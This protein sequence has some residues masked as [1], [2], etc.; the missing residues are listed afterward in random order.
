MAL[1]AGLMMV[2]LVAGDASASSPSTPVP[3]DEAK[4][5]STPDAT[6]LPEPT[7]EATPE[8]TPEPTPEAT[9]EP[10]PEATPEPTPEA[11]PEPTPE[12]TPEPTPEAT[13]EPTPEATPEPTPEATPE[14]TPEPTPEPTATPESGSDPESPAYFPTA[15]SQYI[16]NQDE[17]VG[18][19]TLPEAAGGAGGFTYSLTPSLPEGLSFDAT[20]RALTGTPAAAGESTMTYTATDTDGGEAS[21]EFSIRVQAAPQTALAA[22]KP[23]AP[24]L[25]RTEFSEESDPALDVTWTAPAD[26]GSPITAYRITYRKQ[27][28]TEWTWSHISDPDDR[29]FRITSTTVGGETVAVAAGATYEA[30]V[31]A[32]SGNED[33]DWSDT[34]TGTANRPPTASSVSFLGGTLGVGG[35]FAWHEAQPQGSGAFFSDA[36]SDTLTYSASAQH[37]ALLGVSL[38]GNAGAAVLTANLL[39]QGASNVTYTASDAY[40]GSVTRTATITIT[41][42]TAR[43]IAENSAAGTAVG[44]PVTG[45]PYNDVALS[46]TLKGKAKDSGKFVIDSSSGQISVAQGATLDYETDDSNRETET[47]NGQVIAKFYRGEVHYT[48]DGH[49]AVINV[50]IRVTDMAPGKP[51]TPSVARTAFAEESNPA[52]DVTWTA[53]S[54]GGGTITGYQAQYR[55]Q[56]EANWTY[57]TGELGATATSLNLP[58]LDAG[59]TYEARVRAVASED[60]DITLSVNPKSVAEYDPDSRGVNITVTATREGTAGAVTVRPSLSGGT[61]ILGTDYTHQF[62]LRDMT[63]PD[64]QTSASITTTMS[65]VDDQRAEGSESIVVS[66][67]VIDP[68]S[69]TGLT[70]SDAVFTIMDNEQA[71][72]VFAYGEVGDWSDAGSGTANRPPTTTSASFTGGTFP[73]G[74]IADYKESGQG[75]LGVMFA[76]ADGDTLTYTAASQHPA[77][78]GVSLSGDPGEAQL[79]ATLLNQGSSELTYTATDAYGGSVTRSATIGISAKTSRSIAEYSAGGTALGDP[80]TGTPYNG[81][82][83]SYTLKGKAADSGLFVIDAASG[84]ISVAQGAALDYAIDDEYREIEYWQGKVFNKFYRGEVHYTVDGHAAVINVLLLVTEVAPG[85]PGTP[86]LARTTSSEPM[87]PALDG[88]WT[89]ADGNGLTI[90][91]YQVRYRT[92]GT[93]NW[94]R[95][96]GAVASTAVTLPDLSAGATYEAQVRTVA[97]KDRDITLSVSPGS[98]GENDNAATRTVT[99]TRSGTSGA[100]TVDLALSGTATAGTDY[101]VWTL[102]D[103]TI[104][105]GHTSGS[106]E[107]TFTGVNDTE[108][109]GSESIIVSGTAAGLTVASTAITIIDEEQPGPL[110]ADPSQRF[111]SWSNTGTGTANRPP[112]TT[113]ASFTGGTFPV[114]TIADYKESGQGALGVMFAD[115]DGD[116]LTYTAAS[117]HPALLGVSLS[118]DPGEAQLRATLLNQGSSEL[119][120]TATDAYGGSVTRSATIGITAKTSRSI[121]EY[122]AGGT[123]VGDPVTGT[124]YNNVALSYTLKGKAADSGLF[125]IDAATGQISV[126]PGAAL[127]YA[128]DDEYREIEYWQGKVFNK[129]YRGEVHYTVDGHAAVINVL[130]VVTEVAPGAPGTPTLARTTSSEP[131]DPAL[132]GA[133]TAGAANGLTISGYQVR[134][135]VKAAAGQDP[136]AWT[137]YTGAVSSTAVTLPNLTAGATYEAQVRTV[138]RKDRDITLSVSPASFGENSQSAGITVTA[139]RSGT[140]G[141]V[142]VDLAFAGTATDGTDYTAWTL[143]DVTIADGATSGSVS[144]TFTGWDDQLTEGSE[145]IIV[146]G[147]ATGLTVASTAI[148][149]ID[150]EQPGPLVA[151]PSQR[152]SPWSGTGEGTANTPPSASS[153]FFGGGTL[154]MGGS[155]AWHETAPLGSGAFFTDADSDTLT[156]AAA[157]E[158][159]ALLGVSLTGSAG[160]AVLTANLLNQG[161]S[162]VNYTASDAYG[163]TVTRSATIT[164]TAKTSR[165]IAENSAAGTA[166][167]APVTGT[168]YNNVALSYTLKGKAKDSGKFVI[169]AATGQISLAQGATLDYETDDSHRETETYNGQVIAKFYR[170]EVHYTVN[171]HDAMINV[172]IKVTDVEAGQ[173]N[174]P[175]VT[176][177]TFSEPTNPALDVSWTAPAAN[178]LTITGYEAQYR[179]KAAD[180]EEANAWTAYTYTDDQDNV[181]GTLPATTT[182]LNLPNVDAGATYEVQVRAVTS[183]EGEGPWSDTGSARANRPPTTTS[184]SFLGGT[185]PVGTVANYN[186]T[187]SG[188]VGVLFADADGDSLTYAAAAQHPAL[189]GVSLTGAAAEAKLQVTL[190]NQGS[191]KVTYTATDAYG[192]S[193]TRSATIGITAKTSRSIAE[194]S[195]A[196]TAV[197]APVT[198][199]PY[200]DGDDQTNDALTYTL[201]GKAKDSGKFVIDSATGQISLAQGA[202]LDYETDDSH[203]ETET[204]NG[205]VIAKFYRGEV[206]YTVNSHDAVINVLIKVTDVEAGKPDA[207]TLTRTEFSEPTNPALDVTWTAPD[208][209]GATITGYEVQYRKKAADGEDPAAWTAYTYTDAEDNETSTLPA[210][211]TSLNLPDLDAGATYEAQVR[212]VTSLEG[213]GPWSDSGEK[214]ANTPP[215][216]TTKAIADFSLQWYKFGNGLSSTDLSNGFFQDADGD[217]ISFSSSSEYQGIVKA[218]LDS[219]ALKVRTLNP[220]GAATTVTYGAHDAYGGYVSRTVDVTGTIGTVQASII[221]NA[222]CGRFV[223][224][225]TGVPYNGAALTYTLTGDA[226]VSGPFAHDASSGWISLG[227][228]KSLDYETKSSYTATLSWVVQQQTASVTVNI[229]VRDVEAGKPAKPTLAR[230]EYS[231]PT[232]PGLD[233]TWT[234]PALT[235]EIINRLQI[236]G[237]EVQYRKKAAQGADPAAWTLYKYE[238]PNNA[239][240]QISE[241]PATPTSL[242]LPG[243]EA[244]ATYE[245][246]VRAIGGVEGPGPWSDSGEKQANTPPNVTTKAIADFSLQWYK[247]GNGLSSTD[248]SNGFF[249]DA[250]GDTISFSSSSEY[251]GVVKAWLDS[252]A[253]K[254][255]TLN[256][257]GAAT[258]VTYGAHD[259]YGGYVSR[260][261]DVTGTIGTVQ[262][263]I[264]ENACCGRFVRNITGVPYNGAALTY[265]LTGDAFVSGPFAHDASSGWI[266]LGSGKSLDYETKSSYTATLSWVVQQQTASVTVNIGVRD[267][268]AGKPAKPTLARTEYS[269]PTD[270]G[271]D[272][273]WT[274]PALTGEIINRLQIT[275]YEVQYRKKAAQGADPAAWTLYKY[276]DPNNAGTQISE[277]PATP[278][279]LTLP[280]LEAGATYEVQVRAIGGVE[281]PGPW[282]DSGEGT[283]NRPPTA[284]SA[285]FTGGSFPVGSTADYNET[286]QGALG[287]LF[288]D[289]D[290]DALTYAAA[291]Q[292][293]ALLGVSLSGAA[294]EA[295]LQATLLNQGSSKLTYTASDAYGGAVTRTATIG[296]TATATRSV[297]ESAA[298]GTNVGAPVTGTPYNGVAL[299]YTL[300]GEADTSGN[301]EI[302]SATGQISVKQGAS[303]DYETKDSYSGQVEYT[304]D[305]N[306]SAI[307]LTINLTD[308][309]AP[310]QPAAPTV[311]RTTFSKPTNPALDVTWSAP[312]DNGVTITG[313]KAQYRKKA[314]DGETPAA[315]TSFTGTVDVTNRTLTLPDLDAGATYEVQVRASGADDDGPWSATGEGRANRPPT[316]TSVSM[317]GGTFPVGSTADYNET[318]AGALGV[319]FTDADS[320]TLTYAAAA[321]Q[322]ALLGVSLSGAAES[323][324]LKVTLINPGTSKFTYTASDAYGGSVTRTVTLTGTASASRSVAENAAAGTAVGAAVT[325]T[326]YNNVALTYTLTGEAATSGAFAIDAATGQI[327]VKQGASL[328]YET[329]SSYSGQVGYTVNGYA[330]AITLTISLTDLEAGQ[331]DAPTLVRTEFSEPSDPALDVTWTAPDA[332]GTSISGYEVQYRKKAADG[333]TPAAWTAY[334]YTDDED[335]VTSEL[336]ATTTSLT[337]PDLDAGATYEVQVRARTSL[338]GEGPW[339]TTGEGTA[340]RPPTATSAAFTGGTYAVGTAV[341]YNETG[342]GALGVLFADADGDALTYAAAAQHPALLG[343]SLTGAAGVAKLQATL[344]NQGTS[345]LTYTARDVY[346]GSVTRTVTLIGTATA[347]RSVAENAAAGTKV[348]APVTGTPYNGVALSY[349]LTGEAATSGAFEIDSATGQISVKQGATLDYETKNSYA[350]QVGYTVDGN[351]SAI[352]LTISLTDLEAGQP[353]AP[354]VTRTEYSEP[355]DPALDV[356]WTA[357]TAVAGITISGYEVQYRKKAAEGEDPAAWTT[358]TYTDDEDNVTSELPATTT[359]LTLPGLDAGATYEVQVRA[360]SNEGTGSWSDT[361][362]GTANRPPTATSAAFTGGTYAVGTAVDYN[363][364][365]QGALGVLFADADGD[366]LTY[367]AAAQHPA[368]LGVSLTGAAGEAKLQATLR[369]QGT[370]QLTYTARDAYGGSV[371]RTVTLIGTATASRSVAENAA[372][373]TKVGAPVTGTPYNGVALSYALTGE[374]STSGAFEI[375]SATGQISVKQGATLD[376]ETKNSYAGQVG[377]TVDGNASAI[378]LTISLTDLEAGQPDAPTVTRT[379]YSEPSD[380]A[381]DVTWTAPTAVAGITISGYEAQ[382]RKKAAE[383][384]DPAAWT[385]YTYT[386]DEDNVTSELPATTT[387]LTLPGLDAGATYEVQVRALSNEGTG[388]WSDTGEGTANR[389]PTATSAAFTGGTYAVGTAVDYNET[390]QGALGVLFADADGDTLTYAAAAQHPALLGVSLT[391]AAGEAKLQA[392]LRNQGTSQ[393]TYT[394]RDAYGGSVTRTVTLIGTASAT[395]SVAENAAAGTKVGAPVTGTP[396][397]N[398]AL[399]YT[400]TGEAATSGAFVI[401]SATGQISVKQGAGLDYETKSSYSGQVEY[402]VDGN[403]AAITLT[404]NLTDADAPG[405][406]AAPTVTRTEFS[407][408]SNPALDVTWTAPTDNGVAITGYK[409]QYRKKAADGEIPAAWTS[410]TG[411]VDV[412]NRTLTLPDLTAGA[413]YEVQVRAS[414]ADDDGPWS[415]TGEGT[416]NTPPTATSV[417]LTGGTHAVGTE[418]DYNETGAGAVG[419]LFADADNDTLTYAASAQQPALLGV[420]LSGAA[421]SAKLRVTVINPGTSAVSYVASDG[422]GGAVT[423]T[424]S[425]TGTATASRSVAENATAGTKV[426]A[427][428]TGTPYNNVALTYT[429][430]GEAATSGAFAIDAATGQISV[431]QGAS[432]DYETKSSYSGQV[433]YTVNGYASAITL[434]ISLTDLEAGQPDAPTLV[435]TEFSEPSDPAL[436]VTWTAPDANGTSISG[437]EVQYRKKAADGD[438]PAAW[439]AYTYTDDEDNVTSELPATTTSLTLPDLDAGATYE[440]QVRARTSLEGEGPWSTTGQGTAN[441]PPTATSAAFTGGTYAVGTAVDYNE[442]GQGALGVLFADADGDALTYAA[443]AQHPALLGVSLT[444]AAGVAKLQ[445]TLR[446]QGTSQLTYT[447]RDVYGGS[448]TRTVTL[449]GTAT[450]SRSVAENAAAGTKVGAPVTGTPYN[451]VALSYSLT[452]EAATSGAFEIDSATGQI[453]VKQGAT[454]DYETKNSYTGQVGYTVDG[455][456]SAITVTINVTDLTT[457]QAD[458]PTLARTEFSEPSDP[459]LDVTWTAPTA[460]AGITIS[461][462]E[463]QYRKKA[464]EGEQANA[465]TAYTYTDDEDNVTSELPATTTS[466]TLPGLDAGATYE[467]QVRALSNEGTGSWSD[468]GEGTANRPP[469]ATSAAFT[470]GTYAVGTAVDFNETG[471]GALG[472]LFADAD[473]DALTYA[474]AAQH[475]ALLGV[476]LTGAAGEA[477]LQATLRNQGTS[478]LT[479]TARDAYGGSVTRTVTLIGTATASRSVAENAAAGTKV[480][481]PVTGTPYNGVA[482]SYALT[483]EASTSG[484]FE[485]DSATGQISVKQGATLDYETKNS[486]AG[487]VGYTVDGNASA[488]TLTISLTDLE[489]GQPDAPTVTRTEYSEPSDP[490]LDVTWTAPTAVAGITISGYEVQYRKKAAEGEDPAAWTTYTYTDDEDNVTSELPAT[491][492]S[493]TLPGLDAGATYEVQVRALSNEGTGSW[494]D[495]GEGTANRP[496]TTTAL[497]LQD[498]EID[499]TDIFSESLETHYFQDPDNDALS[500]WASAEY[501]GILKAEMTGILET[502]LTAEGINP[503]SSTVTYGAHDGYGGF[504]SR[505]FAVTVTESVTR[506]VREDVSDGTAVGDPVTG[507]PYQGETLTYTLTGDAADSGDFTIDADSGQISVAEGASLDFAAKSSYSGNV[508]YTVQGQPATIALTINVTSKPAATPDPPDRDP[509]LPP[510]APD[511]PAVTQSSSAPTTSLE[512]DWSA[513]D[514]RGGPAITDYDVEY[515]K[516]ASGTWTNHNF[517]GTATETTLTGLTPGTTYEVQ[518]R[519]RNAHGRSDWSSPGQGTTAQPNLPPQFSSLTTQRS[520]PENSPAGTLV[521]SPVTATDGEGDPLTYT[522]REASSQFNLNSATGQ[523]SVAEGA[524]LDH[525]AQAS[526]TV[527]IQASD[528][529]NDADVTVTITVTDVAEP[530]DQPDA[531][532]VAP[533]DSEE[534]ELDVSWTAPSNDGRPAITDYDLRYRPDGDSEWIAHAV[535]GVAT[536]TTL[537][538][539]EPGTTYEVQVA[540]S[541]DEGTSP[542]SD[543]GTGRTEESVALSLIIFPEDEGDT[544]TRSIAENS[545]AGTPVGAPVTAT[546]TGGDALTYALSGASAFS[547]DAAT[548]QI[549]VAGGAVLDYETTKSYTVTVSV[550]DGKDADGQP[551]TTVDA[552]ADVTIQVLDQLPPAKPDA[553]ALARSAAQP[554]TDLDVSWTAPANQGRP[555]ITDYDVRYRQVGAASWTAHAFVGWGT[556]TRLS[557]LNAD[558]AYEVQVAAANVEGLGPWSDAGQGR[559]AIPTVTLSDPPPEG[560]TPPPGTPTPTPGTPTPPPGTPTPTPGTPTPP[561]GTPTPPP[562]TPTPPP[563]TPTPPP[564]SPTPT[565]VNPTPTPSSPTPHPDAPTPTPAGPTPPPNGP[566]GSN[567]PG[568]AGNSAPTN[569]PSGSSDSPS[570][571]P[572]QLRDAEALGAAAARAGYGL[573]PLEPSLGPSLLAGFEVWTPEKALIF[574]VLGPGLLG[575]LGLLST[576][577]KWKFQ[578]SLWAALFAGLA[579]VFLFF[580]RRRKRAADEDQD[581]ARQTGPLRPAT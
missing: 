87:D 267:V 461:G 387:S 60:T 266:S 447:A 59:A 169:D 312:T 428:V 517:T 418:V 115:A 527:V 212:A 538:D 507:T 156:Y 37:P 284:T 116:T 575:L 503:S 338:E 237:Y 526:Y 264:I 225:I 186:E 556:T 358:Y 453:S 310:G 494:S 151:D 429:L 134:Y 235:G 546:S 300:T 397:N 172:L 319:L 375:D 316:A 128:I 484:A 6:P 339:S 74:T 557:G 111:S 543:T 571:T 191:S 456:A 566:D 109:E 258:T 560:P 510:R 61:A 413:T 35:S 91:G 539:L 32:I 248:L 331:P 323:A 25:T 94:T 554:T 49:A 218:W 354:T 558:T 347:S 16:F 174:A 476:S 350:G 303:L 246:Q 578:T 577:L 415:A 505:T 417:A 567:G 67:R 431:K 45:T 230:T 243:L 516:Q 419:V 65:I 81:V 285:A 166:V 89:A 219:N 330:S 288:T 395:R 381:L 62:I 442:T 173:P 162:K 158:H 15:I 352:T 561:P 125:V 226:F 376:Y 100:V 565:P 77:L 467:V 320:D 481:A 343:V 271:L 209:N 233:V 143:P 257:T 365:G 144:L 164:I 322:P 390:G 160:S 281:G 66:G 391:G 121:A 277:L 255:R 473:G 298:A 93:Q 537:T 569:P 261:V 299:S 279:S 541:N 551:D 48:V 250:D 122:S 360:L 148:T 336:P 63:I 153:V 462:Y 195:A 118:G 274:R 555:T 531:P 180:G 210:T 372:A 318:G 437:Y 10:T 272:V 20:T 499:R 469:T 424:L 147:T 157:A 500:F 292:H 504:I 430:T 385:T 314:A 483:G 471:Q 42:K 263:S 495:T 184:A 443:A 4:T 305:G 501:P 99:A 221:E 293:P 112:T 368:L 286:G 489:A 21:F 199:T 84:Q 211:A 17:D 498:R 493:L 458:A 208:A 47:W 349:S 30:R 182:S 141:A 113:S 207:P 496:P 105:D 3:P 379:E 402:T 451:N 534:T 232:D 136:A 28:D 435:R 92:Q 64:G 410:F 46:Y 525:E 240:T 22:A 202:T 287:V 465:W 130:L 69:A 86:T 409:A 371:T 131:M 389:P 126:A 140:S 165:S 311:T 36:D 581:Q 71:G 466:L 327:S 194:N 251:Q 280:G 479:Y 405:Q 448:V 231:E 573:Y 353:D 518:V 120:Y 217:T 302:D 102:R 408:P 103:V 514:T 488:I 356:T 334:T 176:R 490:G 384:E 377:Y 332:N 474:A 563:G 357:P 55:K 268:E 523:L 58:D 39:N 260:T 366:A 223:R 308:A 40:G 57:F 41:A 239:G 171:S 104:A 373:G 513:P 439:T 262:A 149:I 502:T 249:Q 512:V 50:I 335:N 325:G 132:D 438:T 123:A 82:A 426:G 369:N 101:A 68:E 178:G 185:W 242:T 117:Q 329:K 73:V 307:T 253:L 564:V 321:E 70:V 88:A 406:P 454:L 506:S 282:S 545:P 436:D 12:A 511:R 521:G 34:G 470:G 572:V 440:V 393:L 24:T 544:L 380:P 460:V 83:L 475:P 43:D 245:V 193:V 401:D 108:T 90:S 159:P 167:G 138:A 480:G 150:E 85:A 110:V 294:G 478:Q 509:K 56:G 528:G 170:G 96:S 54:A 485:I 98:F 188:A 213:P 259:A 562:G 374:A 296:I 179:K 265:T 196:G 189:L 412:T 529:L 342:Q 351:A 487:Q 127:D 244:G 326:P 306:A 106:V 175:T 197:G 532:T 216:V 472:V 19:H 398:V 76:D 80:V 114:G 51:G 313:Y 44:D 137:T 549:R 482:L 79:R 520:V 177:T 133:W 536:A 283:A 362:E 392:T 468:T 570:G 309:D 333:D 75:A 163:G 304:V 407:E 227:S 550:T 400:L 367:A 119:T 13:P 464:A 181:T 441:R 425:L 450:A 33:S 26:N 492:T 291:A 427:P 394:A 220:T 29:T 344:R 568:D 192:G 229:G 9:P 452:G 345:Q 190:L 152:L 275:G 463:A 579:A 388:S 315:W 515:R 359:S 548:G 455:N 295:K 204:Y 78:L 23:A 346:G 198:G 14:A 53:P 497:A 403:A 363:E 433:G 522:L 399:S 444:G 445:A 434:T 27:G 154:G 187:G 269:E 559:T 222:C 8:A 446:N 547:I 139:T 38:S 241:L 486:Y 276:E 228:G 205:Q 290:S 135:R 206:H 542:W 18:T 297:A 552:T 457:G 107:L 278:T 404:I 273:T 317:N 411:T 574:S 124:P 459:A 146:T 238:D 364:T 337:L 161:A 236:T 97:R 396:Y 422:Y 524:S 5:T 155:L 2:A 142:T 72:P 95:Y 200:D 383:G 31:Q 252:N 508:E 289:A 576:L 183:E 386:D 256:P 1:A 421:E 270:P 491:T 361:G 449:I 432:L 340:N 145:S 129:F 378:T 301:F 341:D 423:R 355:S 201:K 530:P 580:W 519:A 416:A 7:P 414:G 535:D 328:D 224:N 533:G 203:R 540:A 214:Q 168:P 382:Y 370:S 324:K 348:G 215:N 52:L 254:V 11:T 247:F 234:R 477:K 420:S 553:P